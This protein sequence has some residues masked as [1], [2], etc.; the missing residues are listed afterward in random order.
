LGLRLILFKKTFVLDEGVPG[1]V[2]LGYSPF[3][4]HPRSSGLSSRPL[5]AFLMVNSEFH[6]L[7]TAKANA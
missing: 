5:L 4:L 2:A 1:C 3:H 7:V 6:I